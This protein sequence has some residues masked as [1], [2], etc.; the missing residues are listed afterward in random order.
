MLTIYRTMKACGTEEMCGLS[1]S[2][3]IAKGTAYFTHSIKL[4]EN[5]YA[6]FYDEQGWSEECLVFMQFLENRYFNRAVFLLTTSCDNDNRKEA[7]ALGFRDLQIT[8]DMDVESV[9]Q[10]LEM[11][12]KINKVERYDLM[13]SRVRGLL[14]LAQLGY[15]PD[16]LFIEDQ[17]RDIYQNLKNALVNRPHELFKGISAAGR[18]QK[19]DT[20]LIKYLSQVKNDT[21]NAARV[22]IRMLIEDE[23]VFLDAEQE[24]IKML[25]VYLKTTE[26]RNCPR[27]DYGDITNFLKNFSNFVLQRERDACLRILEDDLPCGNGSSARELQGGSD[28]HLIYRVSFPVDDCDSAEAELRARKRRRS[29]SGIGIEMVPPRRGVV[30][31][32]VVEEYRKFVIFWRSARRHI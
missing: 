12:F 16:E 7:E 30:L 10:C 28:D 24:A 20:K 4:R 23:Y 14:A 17:I 2:E 13:M 22:A 3:I 25:L 15:S 8:G 9:D 6:Q 18:M 31:L 27:D 19:L 11:G 32:D 5:A 1:K 29:R 21:T 26:D